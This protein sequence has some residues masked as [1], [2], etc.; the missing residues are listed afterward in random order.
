MPERAGNT[1][2]NNP[3]TI[4]RARTRLTAGRGPGPRP[5]G[6][7]FAR[8]SRERRN[9][10]VVRIAQSASPAVPGRANLAGCCF[11]TAPAGGAFSAS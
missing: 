11:G 1:R 9:L 2:D 5:T 8:L 3:D 10:E 4:P 6:R 7:N